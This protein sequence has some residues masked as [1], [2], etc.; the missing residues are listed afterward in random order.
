MLATEFADVMVQTY[1]IWCIY[2]FHNFVNKYIHVVAIDGF[3]SI[4]GQCRRF[5]R[6]F[7]CDACHARVMLQ[8]VQFIEKSWQY[9]DADRHSDEETMQ[10]YWTRWDWDST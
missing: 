8:D 5:H 10:A 7:L 9:F 6:E 3:N 4:C 1:Y 2:N